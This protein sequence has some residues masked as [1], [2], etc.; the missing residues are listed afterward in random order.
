ME[1]QDLM[2]EFLRESWRK[3]DVSGDGQ[4]VHCLPWSH[5]DLSSMPRIHAKGQG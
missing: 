2:E 4:A 1:G 3:K 5:E